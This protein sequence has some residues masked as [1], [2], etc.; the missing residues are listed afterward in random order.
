MKSIHLGP[1]RE[2]QYER[3][4]HILP[5]KFVPEESPRLSHPYDKGEPE[6]LM[7]YTW[8]H[9]NI[10][11]QQAEV[12]LNREA[13]NK[14]FL[15]RVSDNDL[16]LSKSV[17]GWISHNI[18]QRS[19]KGYNIQQGD[20]IFKSVPEMIAHYQHY[21]FEGGQVLGTGVATVPSSK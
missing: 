3:I 12:G 19:P 9:G 2:H 13:D 21:P 10:T 14:R 6:D 15:V 11:K 4:S 1:R 20:K 18:I 5:D 7:K 17:S 16:I 8:Y